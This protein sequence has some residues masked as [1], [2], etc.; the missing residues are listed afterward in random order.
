MKYSTFNQC[1]GKNTKKAPEKLN[2]IKGLLSYVENE[3]SNHIKKKEDVEYLIE[4]TIKE[5][6]NDGV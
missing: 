1:A 4:A 2:G 5:A 6:I 3:V